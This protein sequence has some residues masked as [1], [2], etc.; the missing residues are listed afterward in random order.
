MSKLAIRDKKDI[1]NPYVFDR[2]A[3][4]WTHNDGRQFTVDG[5]LDYIKEYKNSEEGKG[6][7]WIE[8]AR[9]LQKDIM[10]NRLYGKEKWWLSSD[11]K[12]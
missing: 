5:L 10:N 6:F 4:V 12:D 1:V 8:L 11:N 7:S 9:D 2:D 3:I